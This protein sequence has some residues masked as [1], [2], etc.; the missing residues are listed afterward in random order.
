MKINFSKFLQV[1]EVIYNLVTLVADVASDIVDD[2]KINHSNR[3][4]NE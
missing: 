4:D 1:F 3:K 2:G